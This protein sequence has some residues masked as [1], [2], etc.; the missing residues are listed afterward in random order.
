MQTT[1]KLS[2]WL[3]ERARA[4][5]K[6]QLFT[7]NNNYASKKKHP[8]CVCVCVCVHEWEYMYE[9]NCEQQVN[10]SDIGPRYEIGCVFNELSPF[11]LHPIVP[12]QSNYFKIERL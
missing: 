11:E 4:K 7:K 2:E 12:H 3:D 5:E 6:L 9:R 8:H 10:D 1:W